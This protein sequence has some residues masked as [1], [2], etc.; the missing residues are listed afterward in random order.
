LHTILHVMEVEQHHEQSSAYTFERAD[1]L[2][3]TDT[4][5]NGGKGAPAGY[6][7]MIWSGF[8]PSDDACTFGYL[9]PANMFA[10]VVLKYVVVFARQFFGDEEMAR[11]GQR[12]HDEVV[13]G[14]AAHGMVAHPRYGQI[15]A[16][17]TDGY[18]H[19]VLMD[20]ANVPSLLSLPYLGYCKPRDPLY[21]NT[22]RFILSSDNPYYW[23]GRAGK[24]VGSPHT[25]ARQIWPIA[26]AMQGLTSTDMQEQ[27]A[28]VNLLVETTAGTGYMHESFHIDDPA[29][30]TRSWFAWANSL[31]SEFLLSWL[32]QKS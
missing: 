20:D 12:L 18:G 29:I 13:A 19:H 25:P 21:Q 24:G 3:P 6:T 17:E 7:G 10:S 5:I 31:F 11:C 8:R 16:Y 14:I 22:R 15:Y 9:I 28:L 23:M 1:P 4:L 2:L 27:E 30:F 26:L 32:R